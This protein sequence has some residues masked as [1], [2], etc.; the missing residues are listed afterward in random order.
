MAT[1][2]FSLCIPVH[3]ICDECGITSQYFPE[4]SDQFDAEAMAAGM[5][6]EDGWLIVVADEDTTK[7]FCHEI[8]KRD[9]HI[10]NNNH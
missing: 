5:A 8:C 6:K 1:E 3:F 7:E 10:D 2:V 9:Y 4:A